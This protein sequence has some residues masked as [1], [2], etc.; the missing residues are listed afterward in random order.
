MLTTQCLPPSADAA[1]VPISATC[2][3]APTPLDRL[4][5]A[6]G[7]EVDR[8]QK[9]R[10]AAPC[11]LRLTPLEDLGRGRPGAQAGPAIT[12]VGKDFCD[13][14][15]GFFHEASLPYRFVRLSIDDPHVGRFDIEVQLTRCRFTRLG[16]YESGG[17]VL[18]VADRSGEALAG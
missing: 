14:G 12:V 18:S 2:P 5:K 3:V 9:S 16:W 10:V 8:R 17:R 1:C 6:L 15:I 4:L 11:L 7:P 13:Q